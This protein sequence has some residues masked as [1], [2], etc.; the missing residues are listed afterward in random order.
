MA[1]AIMTGFCMT[2]DIA[3]FDGTVRENTMRHDKQQPGNRLAHETSP[4]LL[5]HAHNP[6]DW[7]PW[8]EEAFAKAKKEDKPIFLSIGYSACH[9]CHVMAHESFEDE[10]TAALLNRNFVAIKVDREEH[11]DVDAIYM[12]AVQRMTG[13]GG[14]PLSVF[15]TPDLKPFFGGTYFPS[16]ERYG[17]P[18]F[19]NVLAEVAKA[20]KERRK[21]LMTGADN[22][23]RALES[24]ETPQALTVGM[25]NEIIAAAVRDMKNSFDRRWGGFGHAPKFP[26]TAAIALLLRHEA[27]TNDEEALE[28]ITTTLDRMAQGGMYDQV[29]GGFHRYSVDEM[30]LVPHFEKMLY[31]NALLARVYLEAYQLTCRPLYRQVACDTL[32]YVIRDMTDKPGGC[33][34]SQDADSGG[35]EGAYYV[36]TPDEIEGVLGADAASQFS[37]YFGVT[38]EGNF[39]GKNIL[40]VATSSPDPR[41]GRR[42]QEDTFRDSL[43][44]WRARLLAARGKRV[45]PGKD[46]KVIASWNGMMISAFAKGYQVLG[47]QRFR[48]A[49]EN[50]ANFVMTSM[51]NGRELISS[52]AGGRRGGPAYLDDYA[53]MAAGLLD[54][55]EATFDVRWLDAADSLSRSMVDKFGDPEGGGL[56]FTSIDHA[57]LLVRTRDYM[58]GST[59]CG[60][61]VAALT[62]MKLA[63]LMDRPDYAALGQT[64]LKVA[65][66]SVARYPLAFPSMLVAADF[67]QPPALDIAIVGRANSPDT[68]RMLTVVHRAFLPHAVVT[69]ADPADPMYPTLLERIPLLKDRPEVNRLATAYVCEN[70]SCQKPVNDPAGLKKRLERFFPRLNPPRDVL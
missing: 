20:W 10:S 34:A 59:P 42:L 9:W 27:H 35:V 41:A 30:W 2:N 43:A 24:R 17:A 18:S 62:L 56:Y 70:F 1:L 50:A 28:V 58:D 33:F 47:E 31:D 25:G 45:A 32:D 66:T 5:Q 23:T 53:N 69:F 65:A 38:R 51:M 48:T 61:A 19:K 22:M 39:D 16:E 13:S 4:Y 8:G 49:A 11:P 29:G 14:W 63:R 26:P 46:I 60:N 21:D 55:Y 3:G 7:Y 52:Y 37:Q 64:I 15:L 36:W 12:N 40:H 54:L 68:L 44:V 67:V 6:V 57:H